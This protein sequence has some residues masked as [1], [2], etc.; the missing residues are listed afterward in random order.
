M[1]GHQDHSSAAMP[2]LKVMKEA[3]QCG[4]IC[5]LNHSR[6]T[7]VLIGLDGTLLSLGLDGTLLSLAFGL[8][9]GVFV[10]F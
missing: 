4:F 6:K 8:L 5:L 2:R 10:S 9:S 3:M 1:I 7:C